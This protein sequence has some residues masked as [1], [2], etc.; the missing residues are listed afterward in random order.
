MTNKDIKILID[1]YLEGETSPA[2]ERQ[3]A[4]ELQRDGLPGEWQAI[5]LMLG[6]LTI[7]EAEY[8]RIITPR[9]EKPSAVLMAL[10][11]ISS[12]AAIFLLGLFFSQQVSIARQTSV[13]NEEPHHYTKDLSQG[14]TLKNVYTSRFRNGHEKTITYTELKTMHYED[15]EQ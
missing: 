5:R 14:S 15:K 2:E 12:V 6:E 3:L 13:K 8:D 4:W 9:K 1:K 10:R 11:I 7:G